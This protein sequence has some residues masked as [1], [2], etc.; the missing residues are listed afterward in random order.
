M[1]RD[2]GV[3][4]HDENGALKD[5]PV[6]DPTRPQDCLTYCYVMEDGSMVRAC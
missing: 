6:C 3:L 2:F 1:T 4:Q 5:A